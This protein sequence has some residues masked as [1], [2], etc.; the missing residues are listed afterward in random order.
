MEAL[1]TDSPI[2]QDLNKKELAFL[3]ANDSAV[4]NEILWYLER[5]RHY[6]EAITGFEPVHIGSP[7]PITPEQARFQYT[8]WFEA[9]VWYIRTELGKKEAIDK[10]KQNPKKDDGVEL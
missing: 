10:Q 9:M 3:D 8:F 2:L 4:R 5:I 6:N 7:E 1:L